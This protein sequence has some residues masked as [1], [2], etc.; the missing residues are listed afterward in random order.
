MHSYKLLGTPAESEFDDIAELAAQIC[1]TPT[2]LISLIDEQ[3]QWFKSTIGFDETETARDISFCG[4]AIAQTGLMEIPG[5][6]VFCIS[7][8][9][10]MTAS[11]TALEFAPLSIMT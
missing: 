6:N 5:G 7:E 9:R 3:R 8:T 10:W 11:I 2:A 1:G 4:H